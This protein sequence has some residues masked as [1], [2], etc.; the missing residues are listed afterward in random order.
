VPEG[1]EAE[2]WRRAATALVGRTVD[3]SWVDERVA[4]P[5][6]VSELV[7]AS[8]DAVDRIG[9][10]VVVH[11][12]VPPWART[13]TSS[14]TN[15]E[16]RLGLHFGMTGRLVVDGRAAIEQLAYASGRDDA[17]WDRFRLWTEPGPGGPGD[18]ADPGD[19]PVPA[20]R[21]NDPRRLGRVSLDED[22]SALGPDVLTIT[23]SE[24]GDRLARRR[25]AVKTVLL[26]QGAVAGLGNLCADEVLW[27]A[28]IA[29]TRPADSLDSAETAALH[30][31]VSARL[32]V[33]L[34]TGGSTTGILSPDVRAACPPCERDGT[35]LRRTTIGG[36][37]AV[38]C[39]T[40]QH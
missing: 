38:W 7:G 5:G 11:L 17:D 39:P 21:L 37:T 3:R 9:K 35:P 4:P 23:R 26:D 22:L 25:A 29:P 8:I 10:I 27:W 1:L 33:M 14:P 34:A 24:F 16:R 13:R 15:V 6:L 12:T 40:H 19:G 18:G 20:L 28:G 32:P 2:I 30:A 31:A 36:R